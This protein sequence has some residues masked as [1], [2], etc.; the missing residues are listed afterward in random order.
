MIEIKFFPVVFLLTSIETL[1]A[2]K[3]CSKTQKYWKMLEK[4]SRGTL[5]TESVTTKLNISGACVD[6]KFL[7]EILEDSSFFENFPEV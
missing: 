2:L 5:L 1:S 6:Q 7:Q 3:A 4:S